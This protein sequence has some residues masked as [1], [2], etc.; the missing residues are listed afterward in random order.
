[1]VA[2][3]AIRG[4]ESVVGWEKPRTTNRQPRTL[5]H[6]YLGWVRHR[7]HEPVLHSFGYR[8]GMIGFDLAHGQACETHPWCGFRRTAALRFHRDDYLRPLDRPLDQAVREIVRGESGVIADGPIEVLT[9]PRCLGFCFNPVSFYLCHQRDGRLAAIVSEITNTPWLERQVY[10]HPV[11]ADHAEGAPLRVVFAKRFHISPFNGMAQVH[12]W[13]FAVRPG[14]FGVHMRN[15]EQGRTVF[16]ATLVLQRHAMTA[17]GIS[18][19]IRASP[20]LGLQAL[21][22][23][24]AQAARL[25]RKHA[26]FHAHPSMPAHPTPTL[27]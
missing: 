8:H 15:V 27:A 19:V 23:I 10:V 20:L 21:I 12:D 11:P 17:A 26:P 3:S 24:Y 5:N 18:R 25:W 2:S 7:R 13:T 6:I 1:M 9:L 14:V 4:A 16:D 22:R